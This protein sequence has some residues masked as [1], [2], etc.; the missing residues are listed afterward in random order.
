M[1]ASLEEAVKSAK[2]DSELEHAM[3]PGMLKHYLAMK[4]AEQAMLGEWS[5]QKRRMWL[6]E[7]Y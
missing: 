4:D 1:P 2:E 3:S 5:E 7:K 6:M